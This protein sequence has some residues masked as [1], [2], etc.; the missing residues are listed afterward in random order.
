MAARRLNV[1][2][3]SGTGTTSESVRHCLLTLRRLLYPNYAVIPVTE[4]ALV[5]EPWQATCALLVIP[6]GADMGYSR[7]LNGAG[8][9]RI[10]QYVRSGGRYL[11]L[12]AGGYY[13]S[14][15]CEFEVGNKQLEVV[16]RREL[17]LFRGTCR[18]SAYKGFA[19]KSEAGARAVQLTVHGEA[20]AGSSTSK[21][22]SK[23]SSKGTG[24]GGGSKGSSKGGGEA[25]PAG[26]PTSV[27]SYYNGGGVFVDARS[28]DN[29]QVL[30]SYPNDIEVDGGKGRAA[31]IYCSVGEGAAILT[32]PHPECVFPDLCDSRS[33]EY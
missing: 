24:K 11:G 32:G 7:V 22:N 26:L 12:C 23:N 16:G 3:Y 29:V 31:V 1:L 19:Y 9:R 2:V 27:Y 5:K 33:G 8:N 20:F 15:R 18:G 13:G 21:A 30:A 4:D 17:G 28:A 14:G 25:K 10:A 6:G